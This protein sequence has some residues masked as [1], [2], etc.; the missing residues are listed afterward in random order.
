MAYLKRDRI[1]ILFYIDKRTD[2]NEQ[3]QLNDAL[4]EKTQMFYPPPKK[5]DANPV[6]GFGSHIRINSGIATGVCALCWSSS[7]RRRGVVLEF[8]CPPKCKYT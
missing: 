6:A 4:L 3:L 1:G 5:K 7:F 8:S 2:Q